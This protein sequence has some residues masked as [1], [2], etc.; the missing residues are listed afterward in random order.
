MPVALFPT[1]IKQVFS[2]WM[3]PVSLWQRNG[4]WN[5]W[6][7][8]N[9]T[10]YH[11]PSGCNASAPCLRGMA[12]LEGGAKQTLHYTDVAPSLLLLAVTRGGN[13]IFGHV[14]GASGRGQPQVKIAALQEALT[15]F[16]REILSPVYVGWVKGYLDEERAGF[17]A[18]LA[19]GGALAAWRER[20]QVAHPR[21]AL[22]QFVADLQE[23]EHAYWLD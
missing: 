2:I 21:T 19:E 16:E 23:P 20:I 8:R 1:A 14:I 7:P 12:Q 9:P 18:A 15:V 4:G 5:L 22:K 6:K 13:H 10:V 17:E 11:L 3:N